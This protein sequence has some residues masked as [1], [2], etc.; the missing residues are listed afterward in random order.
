[1]E[2][3]KAKRKAAREREEAAKSKSKSISKL[4]EESPPIQESIP[5]YA[6]SSPSSVISCSPSQVFT[7]MSQHSNQS[8]S[9]SITDS[10]P[11]G[12]IVKLR[13]QSPLGADPYLTLSRPLPEEQA[14]FFFFNHFVLPVRD[15]LARK[16]FL[17]HLGPYHAKASPDS[18][19]KLSTLAVATCMMSSGM[20]R[21]PDTPLSRS[22]YLRA[23]S[24]IKDQVMQQK[25]CLEDDLIVAVMLL[26]LYEV[27]NIH[28]HVFARH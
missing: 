19:L 11:S 17:E 9:S 2:R 23:V 27:R 20:G 3:G 22:F 21:P 18:P 4:K 10:P 14:L 5:R 12:V 28:R 26:Q 7:P 25:N 1:M 15:P 24:T 13:P 16:G 8:S 6:E